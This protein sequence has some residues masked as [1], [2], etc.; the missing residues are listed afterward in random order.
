[1]LDEDG[2]FA[3]RCNLSM[4]AL[5]PVP[6]EAE[7]AETGEVE[8][9]GKVDVNPLGLADEVLLKNLIGQHLHYTGSDRARMILSEW[10]TYRMRFV[11]VMPRELADKQAPTGAMRAA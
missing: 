9:H 1:V 2:T 11:K 8:A 3:S 4:V 7:A 10:S 5:E 6:E